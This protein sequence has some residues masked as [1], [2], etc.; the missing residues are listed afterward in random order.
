MVFTYHIAVTIY[1]FF[2]ALIFWIFILVLIYFLYF[3]LND[4][5]LNV[6]IMFAQTDNQESS[7]H[8]STYRKYY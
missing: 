2:I 4:S 8:C 7:N 6:I 5:S 3:I 1:I